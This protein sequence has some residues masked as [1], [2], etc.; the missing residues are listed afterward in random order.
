[1]YKVILQD[2]PLNTT[3]EKSVAEEFLVTA[4]DGKQYRTNHFKLDAI[5]AVG[6]RV[7]SIRATQFR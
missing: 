7:N 1:M 4:S 6:Y 3:E 5:I 2:L